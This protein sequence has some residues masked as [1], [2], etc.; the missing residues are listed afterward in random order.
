MKNRLMVLYVIQNKIKIKKL[1][2]T[3]SSC[4]V[5]SLRIGIHQLSIYN[6]A[7]REI[8]ILA[9]HSCLVHIILLCCHLPIS[10]P[11]LPYLWSPWWGL[12]WWHWQVDFLLKAERCALCLQNTAVKPEIVALDPAVRVGSLRVFWATF[13]G[14]SLPQVFMLMS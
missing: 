10:P 12:G 5:W 1:C 8:G 9:L 2:K 6:F 13:T 11:L 14:V 3:Q 7:I 4:Y